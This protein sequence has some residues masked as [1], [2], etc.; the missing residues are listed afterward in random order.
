MSF[1]Y[2]VL[3]VDNINGWGNDALKELCGMKCAGGCDV[4][5]VDLSRFSVGSDWPNGKV[6]RKCYRNLW[7]WLVNLC[8]SVK[9]LKDL[10]YALVLRLSRKQL[11]IEY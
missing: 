11:V 2:V 9:L 6:R 10:G 7:P 4:I 1:T 8:T 3:L 5:Y